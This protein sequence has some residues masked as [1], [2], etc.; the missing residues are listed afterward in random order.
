M[1]KKSNSGP[2]IVDEKGEVSKKE[3]SDPNVKVATKDTQRVHITDQG[4]QI[5]YTIKEGE[6]ISYYNS[7]E[8]KSNVSN[9]KNEFNQLA[10]LL[11]SNSNNKTSAY[12]DDDKIEV[13]MSKGI[14][15]I[16]DVDHKKDNKYSNLFDEI[17][18]N[19]NDNDDE[20]D[21][22]DLMDQA[23]LDDQ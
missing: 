7:K 3:D 1:T 9:T 19:S 21:L 8:Y 23:V 22:L 20:N 12:N 16:S 6:N 5:V 2:I 15:I 11:S 18:A 13:D 4:E 14:E 10:S 17:K